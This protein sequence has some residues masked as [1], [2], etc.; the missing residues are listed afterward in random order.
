ML[1]I[2][3]A[4]AACKKENSGWD[5]G[6]LTPLASTRIDFTKLL[7]DTLLQSDENGFMRIKFRSIFELIPLDSLLLLPDTTIVNALSLP[8]AVNIP[9]GFSI[10]SQN[11]ELNYNFDDIRI[12]EVRVEEG[13]CNI[14]VKSIVPRNIIFNY[15]VPKAT[16]N[17]ES[18]SLSN[19]FVPAFINDT[20]IFDQIFDLSNYH[21]N[22]TG[23]QNNSF[24]RLRL[25]IDARIANDQAAYQVTP[26]QEFL[27]VENTF[28]GIKPFFARG[29]FGQRTFTNQSS[30]NEVNALKNIEGLLALDQ[31]NLQLTIRNGLGVDL[32]F[33]LNEVTAINTQSNQTV[34]LQHSLVGQNVNMTRALN[35]P[36]SQTG[37]LFT[38]SNLNYELN[39]SNSNLKA[40]FENLPDQIRLN[41]NATINP[42][43]N[44][45]NGNDFIYKKS[46][47][48]LQMD[49][50]IP[51][52]FSA[53]ELSFHDTLAFSIDNTQQLDR[54]QFATLILI[55]DN[56]F[57]VELIPELTL[58]NEQNAMLTKLSASEIIEAAP[59]DND[60]L[61]NQTK[62]SILKFRISEQKIG[63]LK[64]TKQIA[65]KVKM[66]TRP[67]DELLPIFNHYFME[68]KIA[69]DFTYLLQP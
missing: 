42:L 60:L 67:G 44:V 54:V 24:N 58:L 25:I 41:V 8:V 13:L 64:D 36:N 52:K 47:V 43:G 5:T 14:R 46:N 30:T 56:R 18:I 12:T 17:G 53:N 29:Y 63:V 39:N 10:I 28:S 19:Q 40:L 3:L 45:S 26:N 6:L 50:D 38:S 22:L 1:F 35:Q 23:D 32:R 16:L 55:A 15:G 68:L 51:L 66:N 48:N 4:F 7:N 27:K 37:E 61:V 62:R 31:V 57:P 21:F 69:T 49:L 34:S 59:V 65:V 20:V 2:L 33:R 9:P 11:Q